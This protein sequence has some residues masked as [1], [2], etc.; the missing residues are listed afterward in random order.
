VKIFKLKSSPLNY[1]VRKIVFYQ[2]NQSA[3]QPVEDNFQADRSA[4][5]TLAKFSGAGGG[6]TLS[7]ERS[8]LGERISYDA[9]SDTLMIRGIPPNLKDQLTKAQN[10]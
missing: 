1:L 3:E 7:F 2:F 10:W 8:L 6:I 9:S 4:L 5:K